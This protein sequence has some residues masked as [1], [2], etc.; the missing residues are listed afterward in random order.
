MWSLI[1]AFIGVSPLRK[2]LAAFAAVIGVFLVVYAINSITGGILGVFGFETTASLKKK[3]TISEN[4]VAAAVDVNKGQSKAITD[5]SVTKGNELKSIDTVQVETDKV[6]QKA[7]VI[8]K[9]KDSQVA[10]VKGNAASG[11]VSE[12]VA[13][14]Q[15][16]T[17]QINSVWDAYCEFN[18]NSS[19][20]SATKE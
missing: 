2:V 20:S 8:L 15:I 16:S 13:V 10:V 18:E 17:I 4:N 9:K 7:Q 19:C 14:K 1:Q 12:D 11:K 5:I 3:L 6:E